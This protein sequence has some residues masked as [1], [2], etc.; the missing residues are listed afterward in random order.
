MTVTDKVLKNLTLEAGTGHNGDLGA[1]Q[2]LQS[3]D[4][5]HRE[6]V[7]A[8]WLQPGHVEAERH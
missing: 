1:L 6:L 4:G 5:L 8:A 7:V 2:S 3:R